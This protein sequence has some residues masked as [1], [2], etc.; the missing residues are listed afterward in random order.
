VRY[1]VK[2]M[3][4][5]LALTGAKASADSE[6][7]AFNSDRYPEDRLLALLLAFDRRDS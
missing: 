4:I 7:D 1:L 3:K 5:N 6:R 2:D